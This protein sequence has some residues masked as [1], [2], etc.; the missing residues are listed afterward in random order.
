M[1]FRLFLI[2]I[3][4]VVLSLA[5][6]LGL[7]YALAWVEP[8]A[9]PPDGNV[10]KPINVGA[11][12]QTKT[13]DLIIGGDFS[14]SK[15][16]IIGAPAGGN[17]GVGTLNAEQ[18]C[19]Q[20]NCRL[21]WP[22]AVNAF[23]DEGNIGFGPTAVLGT[24]DNV[25]LSFE[26]N[27]AGRMYIDATGKVGIG[28]TT[29]GASLEVK[30]SIVSNV[31]GG[32]IKTGS[33]VGDY[34]VAMYADAAR[35]IIQMA[36]YD[37]TGGVRPL[38]LNPSGGNVGVGTTNGAYNLMVGGVAPRIYLL[39][40][41]GSN[42]ELDF[43]SP[44]MDT[45]WAI[46]RD[47]ATDQLRFW[48]TDNRLILA[49]DGNVGIGMSPNYK[50]D[51]AGQIN[52]STNLS[53]AIQ[54]I[55]SGDTGGVFQSDGV[56]GVGVYGITS[57]QGGSG[58]YGFSNGDSSV[59]VSGTATSLVGLNKGGQFF[60]GNA[61]VVTAGDNN[62]GVI[63]A[64][65]GSPGKNYGGYFKAQGSGYGVYSVVTDASAWPGYFTGGQG[66]Y[67]DAGVVGAAAG[68]WRGTGTLNAAQLCIQGNCIGAWPAGTAPGGVNGQIQF[69]DV[70]VFA[71]DAGLSYDK[72]TDALTVGG[73]LKVGMAA[74]AGDDFIYFD[75]GSKYLQWQDA[76][77]R[78]YLNSTIFIEGQMTGTGGIN[79]ISGSWIAAADPGNQ[80][81]IRLRHDGVSGILD[82]SSTGP[83]PGNL[84]LM[85]T[86]G[87]NFVQVQDELNITGALSVNGNATVLGRNVCLQ[88]GTNCPPGGGIPGGVNSYVQ[89][90]DGG[91]FGGDAGFSY[92]KNTDA[93]TVGGL[94]AVGSLKIGV[95]NGIL[96][97]AGG[98]VFGGATTNDLPEGANLYYTDARARAAISAGAGPVNYT[99]ATGVISFA[100]PLAIFYGGTGGSDSP[101]SGGVAYGTGAKYSFT[102]TG[103]AGQFLRS[104]GAG[105]PSWADIPAGGVGGGG[106]TNYLAKF[107]GAATVGNS[108]IY[109]NGA[110]VQITGNLG[111]GWSPIYK[112]DVNGTAYLGGNTTIAG[113]VGISG[114]IT[115]VNNTPSTCS[116]E[117][118]P[119]NTT[120]Y[121]C[122]NGRFM[123]GLYKNGSGV[124]IYMQCC[125][126]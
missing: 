52:A 30:G 46:Y 126:L 90:N 2:L 23:V 19:I 108:Q 87:A 1:R 117:S 109:D 115:A 91:V 4:V 42:S 27:G 10:P 106:T 97:A 41:P 25:P 35:G 116:W 67:A 3:G 53:P 59:A 81:N 9:D 40:S 77:A 101:T 65:G 45:H 50:L 105:A 68:G 39:P 38:A 21:N 69:N 124:V 34:S 76:M 73:N 62:I 32:V 74:A 57:G 29:P 5:S 49:S 118:V 22:E 12:S 58:L 94:A 114:D 44:A 18:L 125:E 26:T 70:G 66:V 11:D 107:T 123:T 48:R 83:N 51:V 37:H 33:L 102:A 82:T 43:G 120:Y 17:M 24:N 36:N 95:L 71:G 98:T 78:F 112:L 13:G 80:K 96:K 61:A 28:T 79:T 64:A 47:A 113:G 92:D 63:G 8:G 121:T 54:G 85:S 72:N 6:G 55:S 7:R 14:V 104:N 93:L 89:F 20:G 119:S 56:G 100:S 60:A 31:A 99:P 84:V 75:D 88:D 103:A 16:Q 111:I 110:N 86:G 122:A 15:G